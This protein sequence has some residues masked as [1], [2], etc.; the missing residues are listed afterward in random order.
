MEEARPENAAS[1]FTHRLRRGAGDLR[2][3]FQPHW[4]KRW[5][6]WIAIGL[7]GLLLAF[8]LLWL[9]FARGLPY[10]ATLL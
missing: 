7:G 5:F 9:I 1:S 10:A 3:R 4:D 6:R 2:E 8:A